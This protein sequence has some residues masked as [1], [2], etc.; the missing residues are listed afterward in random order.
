MTKRTSILRGLLA[1]PVL[2][3]GLAVQ[4]A[5]AAHRP[6][7]MHH[8]YT[9]Y[10]QAG[11]AAAG[12]VFAPANIKVKAGDTIVWKDKNKVP[13]N[14]VGS[15]KAS[16]FIAKSAVDVKSYT[17]TFKKAG[18]YKYVCQVHPGMVGAVTVTK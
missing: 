10:E 14:V 6:A 1:L 15:D 4:P 13:H 17:L 7:M 12:Y 5:L 16:A 11:K 3:A 18:T 9:V 2:A 8:T